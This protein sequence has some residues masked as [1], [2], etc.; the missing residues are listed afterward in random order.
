MLRGEE[1]R[2]TRELREL[3]GWLKAQPK[4]DVVC[5]GTALLLGMARRLRAELGAPVMCMFQGEH[6][7]MDALPQPFR[8]KCW[9]ELAA[10]AKEVDLLAAP[11]RYY[12]DLM[13]RR[14]ALD[15]QSIAV[16]PNGINLQGFE[17]RAG[18]ETGAPVIGFF[19]RMCADKGLDLL[20]DAYIELRK[21]R[22]IEPL[23]L[24]VGGSCGPIDE[25]YVHGLRARLQRGG[26]LGDV[27]FCPNPDHAGKVAFLQSLSIFSVPARFEEAFGLYIIE[28]MA[29]GVPVVQPRRG[30]FTE[31][32][33]STG[34]GALY[35]GEKPAGLADA[36]EE[37]LKQ[38]DKQRT[39]GA[40]GQEAVARHFTA[41]AMAERMVA[42]WERLRSAK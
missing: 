3:I 2:Q 7:F 40:A 36:L 29:A 23:K 31:V 24:K 39:L 30:A 14:L 16:V 13:A 34:G 18:S 10:R 21:A 15:A 38:P 25:E 4:P 33:E 19:A 26:L 17:N 20:V 12:A 27:E 42:T 9:S 28:A 41:S 22:K 32:V 8:D 6:V 35:D 5:L 1:G 11:S 37:L